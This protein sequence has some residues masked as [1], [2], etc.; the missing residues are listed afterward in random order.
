MEQEVRGELQ[1]KKNTKAS[2]FGRFNGKREKVTHNLLSDK[3]EE[4]G[5]KGGWAKSTVKKRSSTQQPYYE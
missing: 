2:K 4:K 1:Y 3:E 5:G